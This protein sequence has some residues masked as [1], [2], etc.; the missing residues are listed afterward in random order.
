MR[1]AEYFSLAGLDAMADHGTAAVSAT[2]RHRLDGAFKTVE[3]HGAIPLDHLECPI[4]IIA[5]LI[6]DCHDGPPF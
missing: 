4:I 2:R 1:A 6:A 3:S 5:A